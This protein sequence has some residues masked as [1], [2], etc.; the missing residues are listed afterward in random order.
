MTN[1]VYTYVYA[2]AFAYPFVWQPL[3]H[4]SGRI[5]ARGLIGGECSYFE[6]SRSAASVVDGCRTKG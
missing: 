6:Y 4:A 1:Y 3:P 2:H 5:N